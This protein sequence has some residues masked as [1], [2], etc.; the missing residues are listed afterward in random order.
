MALRRSDFDVHEEIETI[1]RHVRDPDPKVSLS[2]LKQFR[3]VMKEIV[4]M[5]GMIAT[6]QQTVAEDGSVTQTVSTSGLLQDLR[7][8]NEHNES[9]SEQENLAYEIHTAD[10]QEEAIPLL[11]GVSD[12]GNDDR[13]DG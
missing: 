4:G 13:E 11:R 8:E 9:R 6:A 7:K 2:A 10:G 1:I 3:S 5:N 12:G